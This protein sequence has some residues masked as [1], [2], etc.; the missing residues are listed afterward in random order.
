MIVREVR[1]EDRTREVV[2]KL[3]K[4]NGLVEKIKRLKGLQ[5]RL[6]EVKA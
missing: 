6:Q 5:E 4:I 1:V 2:P 3:I